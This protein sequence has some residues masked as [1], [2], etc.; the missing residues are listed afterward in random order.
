MIISAGMF[1]GLILAALILVAAAPI[2][3]LSL[4]FRDRRKGEL[5]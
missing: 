3:L 4:W 5:W 2:I 1:S